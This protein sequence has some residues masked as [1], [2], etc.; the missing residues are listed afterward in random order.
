MADYH[1]ELALCSSLLTYPVGADPGIT[2][3]KLDYS[4][5]LVAVLQITSV[6]IRDPDVVQVLLERR[7]HFASDTLVNR[8]TAHFLL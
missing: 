4:L 1:V 3:R 6:Q 5:A 7:E 8:H 2:V